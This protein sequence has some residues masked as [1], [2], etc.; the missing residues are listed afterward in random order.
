M[1]EYLYSP[2]QIVFGNLLPLHCYLLSFCGPISPP[3][4]NKG[5]CKTA[6]HSPRNKT[7]DSIAKVDQNLFGTAVEDR[8][9]MTLRL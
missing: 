3:P 9:L 7:I 5:N 2:G 1:K 8:G 6:V 4:Q